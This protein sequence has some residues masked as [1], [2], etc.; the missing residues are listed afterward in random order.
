[1]DAMRCASV[2]AACFS[3]FSCTLEIIVSRGQPD[4]RDPKYVLTIYGVGYKFA[5]DIE[6]VSSQQ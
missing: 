5:E 6:P 3:G 1:M 2:L 4:P